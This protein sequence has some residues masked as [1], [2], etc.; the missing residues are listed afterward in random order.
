MTVYFRGIFATVEQ[1]QLSML[2]RD[3]RSQRLQTRS[4]AFAQRRK[5]LGHFLR[6]EEETYFLK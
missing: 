1:L 2:R 3:K 6:T 5:R 4:I